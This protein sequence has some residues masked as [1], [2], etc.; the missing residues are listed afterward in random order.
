MLILI[1]MLFSFNAVASN[2]SVSD[3]IRFKNGMTF[4]HKIHQTEKVGKCY[5]CHAN[6]SV[7]ADGKTVTTSEPGKIK[8][9]G[10]EW[11]HKYCTDCH[12]LFGE[13]PVTCKD[14]HTEK[15]LP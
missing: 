3:I 13:G 4:N 12:E 9:F 10:K 5:V 7:S 8:G 2:A 11:S 14:C 1:L 15:D 6:V